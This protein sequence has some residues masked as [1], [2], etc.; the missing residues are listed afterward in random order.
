MCWVMTV[1]GQFAGSCSTTVQQRLDAA[2]RRADG[3]QPTVGLVGSEEGPARLARLGIAIEHGA[4]AHPRAGGRLHL[5]GRSANGLCVARSRLGDAVDGAELQGVE[6][7]LGALAG[8]G[9]DHDHRHRPQPHDLLEELEA[10]HVR[11]LDVERDDVRIERLDRLARLERIAARRRP[12]RCRDRARSA[13]R[14]GRAW[15]RES[16]TTRTRIGVMRASRSAVGGDAVSSRTW[17]RHRP[18]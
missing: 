14:S 16:S 5:L 6:R 7:R 18:G 17:R 11:H 8:Q 15:W 10:V 4:R 9:R 3:Q 1:G 12:P 13:A 2:G